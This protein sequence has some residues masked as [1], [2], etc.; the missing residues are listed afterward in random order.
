MFVRAQVFTKGGQSFI[1]LGVSIV[2]YHSSFRL[3]LATDLANPQ[4]P[5]EL[6]TKACVECVACCF[7]SAD[8]SSLLRRAR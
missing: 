4:F 8:A 2:P 6:T 7:V 1:E 3:Y 5:L